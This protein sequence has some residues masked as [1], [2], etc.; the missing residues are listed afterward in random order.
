MK[1]IHSILIV[2]L[3]F[4]AACRNSNQGSS[5]TDNKDGKLPTDLV[6]NPATASADSGK[7]TDKVPGFKFDVETHDFGT[8]TQGEKVAYAFKFTNSGHAD[9][10]IR[11]AHASCGCTVPDYPKTPVPPG[12]QGVINVT[13][14]SEGKNGMQHKE[15][16]IVANTIPNTKV[17]VITG[18]VVD[19]KK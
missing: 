14:N 10:L 1:S 7:N 2:S 12:G 16:T 13:F 9:L 3:L 5:A 15:V 8:I 6:N 19:Q 11:E 17:L 18:E 4:F